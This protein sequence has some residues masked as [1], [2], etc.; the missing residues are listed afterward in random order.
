MVVVADAPSNPRA[1]VVHAQNARL[2]AP[3]VM[4]PHLF[5]AL[6]LEAPTDVSQQL[7]FVASLDGWYISIGESCSARCSFLRSSCVSCACCRMA[8]RLS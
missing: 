1:V 7:D 3:A 5:H 8:T 6:A 4:H 2:A